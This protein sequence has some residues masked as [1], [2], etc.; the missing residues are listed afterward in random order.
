MEQVNT[1]QRSEVGQKSRSNRLFMILRFG[2]ALLLFFFIL[3]W[4]N[5]ADVFQTFL[6]VESFY[7]PMV[8][9][10][11]LF[12]RYLMAY[13]WAILLRMRGIVIST[14][15]AFRIY[16][17]SGFVGTF[18]PVSVGADIFRL[19]RTTLAGARM[20]KVMASILV[21]RAIGL[22]SITVLGIV[23]LSFLVFAHD[24][25]FIGLY[26]FI[27]IFL[28]AILIGFFFVL[29]SRASYWLNRLLGKFTYYRVTR[30][31][32][33]SHKVCVEMGQHRRVIGWFFFLSLFEQIVQAYMNYL[34][35]KALGLPVAL[36]YF[37]AVMPV[38][39]LIVSLPISISAIGVQEVALILLFSMAGLSGAQSFSLA[40][41]MRA[42]GL[43]M[44]I[45]GGIIF[46]RDTMGVARLQDSEGK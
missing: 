2:I 22:L 28:A 45:P 1:N 17:A 35:A 4:V 14:I 9:I 5:F 25:Q 13:K 40:L 39:N 36:I 21:E 8:F 44:L 20:D 23:G 31:I 42:I 19:G 12:D 18:L 41:F 43:I 15:E 3:K 26:Y 24:I 33:D 6:K 34:C 32:L 16:M 29:H 27:W 37:F 38:V 46:L 11:A 7:I 10:L 30:L